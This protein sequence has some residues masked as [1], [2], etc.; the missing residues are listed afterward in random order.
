MLFYLTG[1]PACG[2]THY[3]EWLAAHHDFRHLD[4]EREAANGSDWHQRWETLTPAKA[5]DFA[6]RLRKQHP[7]WVVTSRVPTGDLTQLEALA[8]AG[9]SLWFFL[10]HTEGVSRQRWLALE[11]ETDPD[12]GPL[13]WKKQADA[14]RSSARGLR[15]FFRNRCVETLNGSGELLDGSELA[16]RLGLGVPE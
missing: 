1:W 12:A 15:P 4:L 16:T 2:E 9:F 7:R 3:G 5:A 13:P 11:R 10:A 14:I 6:A 8:A